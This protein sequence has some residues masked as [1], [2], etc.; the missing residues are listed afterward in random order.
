MKLIGLLFLMLAG[1]TDH[2]TSRWN[3]DLGN[4]RAPLLLLPDASSYTSCGSLIICTPANP[5]MKLHSDL[6]QA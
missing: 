4:I 2:Q 3:V 6:H 5:L 1:Q